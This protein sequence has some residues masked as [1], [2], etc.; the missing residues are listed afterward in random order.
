N[1]A[2]AGSP[3]S[4]STADKV[5]QATAFSWPVDGTSRLEA[6]V[7][8]AIVLCGLSTDPPG[9][10]PSYDRPSFFVACRGILPIAWL[11]C[12]KPSLFSRINAT[13][14]PKND[15]RTT[16]K[17]QLQSKPD[18]PVARRRADNVITVIVRNRACRKG[19][20]G[21]RRRGIGKLRC[22]GEP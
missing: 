19:C 6:L 12:D 18:L 17:N 9:S 14:K 1:T 4:P 3:G 10:R 11:Y 22:I 15:V 5:R 20:I 2:P 7:R 8:Q 21:N 16:S 13:P